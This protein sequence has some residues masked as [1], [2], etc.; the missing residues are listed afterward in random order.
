MLWTQVAAAEECIRPIVFIVL[1]PLL[2]ISDIEK[3][4]I[5]YSR[6]MFL[7]FQYD[8]QRHAENQKRTDY[9]EKNLDHLKDNIKKI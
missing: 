9:D 1:D 5:N 6:L 2:L 7:W 8:L 3:I 4:F